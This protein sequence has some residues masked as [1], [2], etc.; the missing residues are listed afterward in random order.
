M[1]SSSFEKRDQLEPVISE[2]AIVNSSV[3]WMYGT[4]KGLVR[5]SL[6]ALAVGTW[7]SSTPPE[8][9]PHK[10][11]IISERL[12]NSSSILV[13]EQSPAKCQAREQTL[14]ADQRS[15]AHVNTRCASP[16]S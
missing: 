15:A 9:A 7:F 5:R 4:C 13:D 1:Q 11:P 10:E 3:P 6:R 12:I 14:G 2:D 16:Y 8:H